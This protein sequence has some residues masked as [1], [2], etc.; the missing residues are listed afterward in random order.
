MFKDLL[1]ECVFKS[2]YIPVT[3]NQDYIDFKI[4]NHMGF[5]RILFD[6]PNTAFHF[7]QNEEHGRKRIVKANTIFYNIPE[8]HKEFF[9]CYRDVKLTELLSVNDNQYYNVKK[10][11]AK[12][13][14][15]SLMEEELSSFCASEKGVLAIKSP[16]GTG[17]SNIIDSVLDRL[18]SDKILFVTMR[19][20]LA[21]EIAIKH[22]ATHYKDKNAYFADRL[23]CQ[24]DS[25][26]QFDVNKFDTIILDE[27]QSILD[28]LSV[29]FLW[30]NEK[31]QMDKEA[32]F[33]VI[34]HK[35]VFISDAF[36]EH[37]SLQDLFQIQSKDNRIIS[38]VEN[39]YR[40]SA[41]VHWFSTYKD[42]T[43]FLIK[44]ILTKENHEL[45][46]L[47]HNS[48]KALKRITQRVSEMGFRVAE[49]TSDSKHDYNIQNLKGYDLVAYSPTIT[50][51]VN[52]LDNI[53]TH[54]HFDIGGSVSALS[55]IQMLRRVRQAKN[56]YCYMK[57]H[58]RKLNLTYNGVLKAYKEQFKAHN[59]NSFTHGKIMI[60][61]SSNYYNADS[62]RIFRE[63]LK[64]QF[65]RIMYL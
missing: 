40:D 46:S 49:I 22:K 60:E 35:R 62:K 27:F 21:D 63:L 53:K 26:W 17:K 20:S 13:L 31:P 25:L 14:D 61:C 34:K 64:Q 57:G 33:E 30:N 24:I 38:F 51:G 58:K 8:E 29:M 15:S 36:L 37:H 55:S 56:I 52:I 65:S 1:S 19:T 2:G 54:F 5:Y 3:E 42:N 18:P 7:F 44:E 50:V 16:M 6:A 59:I 11:E 45:V 48:V 47:S 4:K 43:D 28:Y 41:P 10:V 9:D 23:V 39:D 32:L 12:F